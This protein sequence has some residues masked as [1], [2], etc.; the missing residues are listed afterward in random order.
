MVQPIYGAVGTSATGGRSHAE[1]V[2]EGQRQR[3]RL[4][5][6]HHDRHR[7]VVA[8]E[9]WERRHVLVLA[10]L[11]GEH[12]VAGRIELHDGA[13]RCGLIGRLRVRQGDEGER[14]GT[15]APLQLGGAPAAGEPLVRLVGN[16]LV[17]I[18]EQEERALRRIG[19]GRQRQ[20]VAGLDHLLQKVERHLEHRRLQLRIDG[21][22][23]G[24][25]SPPRANRT[26]C[27]RSIGAPSTRATSATTSARRLRARRQLIGMADVDQRCRRR[28]RRTAAA[29]ARTAHDRAE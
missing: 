13:Q 4:H 28:R 10:V 15:G 2:D 8:N 21:E 25:K 18:G 11:A 9:G 7:L 5:D 26:S 14:M 3:V 16:D 29:A 24:A 27:M 1:A 6:R 17:G 12:A 23:C 22:Q 19:A 20:P